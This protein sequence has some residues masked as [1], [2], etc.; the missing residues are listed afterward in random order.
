[1][2]KFVLRVL[3]VAPTVPHPNPV[4]DARRYKVG[5]VLSIIPLEAYQPQ[6]NKPHI[7]PV[8]VEADS[9][10]DLAHLTASDPHDPLDLDNVKPKRKVRLDLAE[11][12]KEAG[13]VE[14]TDAKVGSV[15]EFADTTALVK[16]TKTT[17][18]TAKEVTDIAAEKQRLIDAG[19]LKERPPV[20]GEKP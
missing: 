13:R 12:R 9:I 8:V 15:L 16:Q 2:A 7:K 1:M 17:A 14:R 10:D 4:E 20:L 3:A 18:L 6:W 5:D 11:L 19:E